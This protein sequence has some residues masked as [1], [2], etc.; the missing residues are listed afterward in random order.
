MPIFVARQWFKHTVGF[1]RN[2]VSRRYVSETPEMW[3]PEEWRAKADNVKQGSS[4]TE[5]IEDIIIDTKV[6]D[7][8]RDSVTTYNKMIEEGYAPEQARMILPQSMM[9]EFIETGNLASYARL[10]KLR[11]DAHAQKEIQWYAEAVAE[12]VSK[13]FPEAFGALMNMNGESIDVN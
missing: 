4:T 13:L 6:Y 9:T 1:T 3:H 2:E 8:A 12:H 7:L 10:C 11:L 5:T